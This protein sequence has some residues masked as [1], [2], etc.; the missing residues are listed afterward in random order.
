MTAVIDGHN[1]LP[2]QL[3]TRNGDP[4][5]RTDLSATGLH[6]DIP[7]L[8]R[9]KVAGQW[10][11]VYVPCGRPETESV[12][13]VLEQIDIVHRLVAEYPDSLALALTA[14]DAERARAEGRI[15]SLL[16]A[17][18]GHC[19]NNSLAV[20]RMLYGLGVRYMTLTHSDNTSWADSATD[21]PGVGGLSAFGHEVVREMNRLGMLVDLSHVATS[22]MHAALD[23][24]TAPAFFSHSSARGVCDHPRNVPDDVLTRVRDTEGVVMVAFVPFFL[25]EECRQWGNAMYAFEDTLEGPRDGAD[26]IVAREAWVAANPAPPA[27]IA[28]VA[29]HIEHI[30]AVAGVGAVGLGGDY[31]GTPALPEGLGDVAGYPRLFE[32]LAGRGWSGD[33]LDRLGWHNAIRVLRATEAA[34]RR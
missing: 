17:E 5:L 8:T 12:A 25:N 28:D 4:D 7:R 26:W 31:D 33:D 22:T 1:D 10:W 32:E 14:D 6:T 29:D 2:W 16:G 21:K 23:T 27:S 9:G 15:A 13:M 19:I 11:S 24:S 18:G 34:A 3:R 20:L 30:R